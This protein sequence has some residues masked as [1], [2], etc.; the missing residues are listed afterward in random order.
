MSFKVPQESEPSWKNLLDGFLSLS[1]ELNNHAATISIAIFVIGGIIAWLY[2]RRPK[3]GTEVR[4]RLN[5][6]PPDFFGGAPSQLDSIDEAFLH[7]IC[8]NKERET[9]KLEF[10]RELPGRSESQKKEFAKDVC[11]MANAKG[12]YLFYGIEEK[13]GAASNIKPILDESSD[14]AERRL[15]QILY[16]KLEPILADVQFKSIDVGGGY[17]L[18]IHVPQSF[19][20]PHYVRDGDKMIFMVRENTQKRPLSYGELHR[21]FDKSGT[22]K[23]HLSAI[24]KAAQANM[25]IS[26]HFPRGVIDQK[27]EKEIEILCKTRLFDEFNRIDN[28]LILGKRVIEGEL[29]GGTNAVRSRALAWCARLLA[30][31]EKVE[32]A[33]EYLGLAKQLDICP[34]ID[35]AAAFIASRID[36]KEVALNILAAIDSSSAR[37]AAFMVVMHR[38]GT[39]SAIDWLEKTEID[40]GDMDSE[41]KFFLLNCQLELA[42]WEDAEETVRML[43]EYDL[44]NTP[45]L[46]HSVA[47]T[48]LLK[49]VPVEFR[50]LVLNQLPLYSKNFPLASDMSLMSARETAFRYFSKA[51]EVE[52]QLNCP[53]IALR[54]DEYAL[55][56]ELR[57]PETADA[58]HKRL[59][60]KLRDLK[61]ALHLVPLGLQFEIDFDIAAV[62]REIERNIALHG[63]ITR[64]AAI[65]N[66]VLV[67]EQEPKDVAIYVERHY[68]DLS[69]FIDEKQIS[70]LRIEALSRAGMPD[71]AKRHLLPLSKGG[72][73]EGDEARLRRM[74]AEASG[75]NPIALRKD[76]F[77]QTDALNDLIAL[78]NE[79][80]TRESWSE[81]CKFGYELFRRTHSVDDAE[82]L[83][84]ALFNIQKNDEIIDF[85]KP[86][87]HLLQQS[88]NLQMLYCWALYNEGHFLEARSELTKLDD[89]WDDPNYRQLGI[90]LGIA[91]GDWTSLLTH[92]ANEYQ[93]RDSRNARDLIQIA[94]LAHNL[95][96]PQAKNLTLA[97]ADKGKDD[98]EILVE[99]Y[100]LAATAGWENEEVV[101]RW[102]RKAAE[103][104]KSDGPI[105]RVSLR[106]LAGWK[107]EWDR[108]ES[109]T[110][111][112]LGRGDMPMFLAGEALNRTLVN[113]MLF[114]ALANL[115]KRD[116]RRRDAISAY[117]GKRSPQPLDTTAETVGIDASALLTLGFLD[118]LDEAFDAFETVYVPHSTLIWLFEEKQR[119]AFHQPS[120][121]RDAS[122]IQD[123]IATDTLVKFIPSTVADSDLSAQVGD[124]LA[125]LIA[126]A[127][128][129][130]GEEETQH[131][132]V[133]PSP[134]HR[135]GSL[136]DEEVDL[137]GH[138]DVISSCLPI[139]EKLK[140]QGQITANEESEARAYLQL[141]EKPWP[142]QPAI[143]DRAVL[144]L[145]D[146]AIN[147]FL[148]LGMLDK[149]KAAGFKAVA[150]PSEVSESNALI[151][152]ESSAN[153]AIGTIERIRDA[154]NSRIESGKIKVNR[155]YKPDNLKE[156][157]EAN[158]PT[159]GVF[160]L[161][162]VCDA[163]IIDDRFVNQHESIDESG[164]KATIFSTLDLLD[165][166]VSI[167]A[168]TSVQRMEY[169]TLLRRAG[170]FF[171]PVRED[172]LAQHLKSCSVT[173]GKIDETAELKAIRENLLRVR[174]SD[175]LQLPKE[176]PWLDMITKVFITVLKGFWKS[177]ADLSK[178]RAIS[179]WIVSQIDTRGWVHRLDVEIADGIIKTGRGNCAI[180][181]LTPPLNAP[182]DIREAYWEWMEYRVLNQIKEQSPEMYNWIVDI[183]RKNVLSIADMDLDQGGTT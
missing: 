81:F 169:R 25:S 145:D 118:L 58:G 37:T 51:A 20:G 79:L 1:R 120:R 67:L 164:M 100:N 29:S 163:V 44:D 183:H 43:S 31:S 40:S 167:D 35:I 132:V 92:V 90:N 22:A 36:G 23:R 117:S 103:L 123:M 141:H 15:G 177:G 105:R 121:I 83:A 88:K 144:Y 125:I 21:A 62:K 86:F 68:D 8:N 47:I 139:V 162:E 5:P 38:E 84:R 63:G 168:I 94:H 24:P 138:A 151:S 59:E 161:A 178:A 41:G 27:I 107:P 16:R 142:Q 26:P 108:R 45:A 54:D 7:D 160:A 149:L 71:E 33:K 131:I 158:H 70:I 113:L 18:L 176:A 101:V 104:S 11:A 143:S 69:K 111:Q 140:Q 74:I 77:K 89:A 14:E 155:Q 126:E 96:S 166:L 129:L 28:A 76:Q 52:R 154:L 106:D 60:D 50:F 174:M 61:S 46:Y 109:E 124:N 87:P 150:S 136:I 82:R 153:K 146:L 171:I 170:Y 91:L 152:Y 13:N 2:G 56:L 66:L 156:R 64:E 48:Y 10:K 95:G 182:G 12:G 159:I 119:T 180:L 80:Y 53:R 133:R 127:E 39:K 57:N 115:S 55:W 165:R 3:R 49:A 175:W 112:A 65:A 173:D 42:Q 137:T 157:P 30:P 181:L 34:E 17:V 73:S 179:D 98:P 147:Y 148:H 19:I 75:E 130:G 93:A 172:E 128:K 110:W 78:V 102:I 97:A 4:I 9:D 116:P 134:V 72:I 122:R 99:A 6:T 85:L 114:P 32:I 135:L